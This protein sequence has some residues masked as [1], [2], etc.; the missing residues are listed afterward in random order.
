MGAAAPDL[1]VSTGPPAGT[2]GRSGGPRLYLLAGVADITGAITRAGM[3][4]VLVFAA[5]VVLISSSGVMSPGPLFATNV[6]YG[7]RDGMRAGIKMAIGHTLVELPL[8]LLLGAGL[9]SFESFPQFRAAVAIVGALG[10]FAFA[11]LQVRGALGRGGQD[12]KRPGYGPLLAGVMLTAL[13]PFFIVWWLTIGIKL[14]SDALALWSFAGLAVL[15]GLHIWMD[16]AWMGA[17]GFASKKGS[18]FMS[19][20]VRRVLVVVLSAV[21]VYFGVIFLTDGLAMA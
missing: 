17:V 5:A 7:I 18:R 4:E 11:A 10:L 2:G 9:V 16:Y 14:I 3:E 13:N 12:P 20:R 6:M 21:L 19:V 15:F 8:I 1:L